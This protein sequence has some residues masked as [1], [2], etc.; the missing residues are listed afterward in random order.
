MANPC[1]RRAHQHVGIA[2]GRRLLSQTDAGEC[3]VPQ[4]VRAGQAEAGS[5]D[6]SGET[7]HTSCGRNGPHGV[8]PTAIGICSPPYDD[9]SARCPPRQSD[10]PVDLLWIARPRPR[11]SLAGTEEAYQ[12]PAARFQ[13]LSQPIAPGSLHPDPM[14][15][16]GA[17]R[18]RCSL[19]A[20]CRLAEHRCSRSQDRGD[21][22]RL[23]TQRRLLRSS[24]A[25]RTAPAM[26]RA[27]L[28]TTPEKPNPSQQIVQDTSAHCCRFDPVAAPGCGMS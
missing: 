5:V 22:S 18:R 14:G 21:H 16:K 17:M 23:A 7:T 27:S 2:A 1:R 6:R 15:R 19:P 12:L 13:V 24:R 9:V 20:R 25:S 3:R 11:A 10:A 4:R 28:T 26:S 8:V